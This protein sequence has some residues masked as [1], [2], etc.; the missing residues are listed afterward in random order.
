[1]TRTQLNQSQRQQQTSIPSKAE[2]LQED[3]LTRLEKV[4]SQP[5]DQSVRREEAETVER[6]R[7]E[8]VA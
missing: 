8:A 2:Q 6:L 5:S 4:T 1:M 7:R 3:T